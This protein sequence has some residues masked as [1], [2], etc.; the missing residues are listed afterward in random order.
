M[1]SPRL[2]RSD[3]ARLHGELAELRKEISELI[4]QIDLLDPIIVSRL[5]S[6]KENRWNVGLSTLTTIGGLAAGI[7]T[8][9]ALVVAFAG[10]G[11]LYRSGYSCFK[12]GAELDEL[13]LKL[14]SFHADLSTANSRADAI[15]NRLSN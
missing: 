12:D 11:L 13:R 1:A 7:A 9:F 5:V 6:V 8:P 10:I 14:A 15:L 2:S 3:R 4:N